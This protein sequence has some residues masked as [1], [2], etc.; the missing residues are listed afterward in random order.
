AS[1]AAWTSPAP[2]SPC[3]GRRAPTVRASS[4]T[5]PTTRIPSSC[6]GWRCTPSRPPTGRSEDALRQDR[7]HPPDVP[8]P[9]RRRPAD[10]LLR[11]RP[12]EPRLLLRVAGSGP[13]GAGPL[14]HQRGLPSARRR[15][16]PRPLPRLRIRPSSLQDHGAGPARREPV[17]GL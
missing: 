14:L 10:V 5:L 16:L 8:H 15:D 13:E 12:H 7:P 2:C 3:A 17:A 6:T 1:I 9:R 11:R 4:S